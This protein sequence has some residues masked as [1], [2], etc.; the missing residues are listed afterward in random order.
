MSS[1]EG[2][3]ADR[4]KDLTKL[5]NERMASFDTLEKQRQSDFSV[6]CGQLEKG[7]LGEYTTVKEVLKN[8][9]EG[10]T[11][12]WGVI[13][14]VEQKVE[15]I[16]DEIQGTIEKLNTK[17]NEI[18][19]I[20]SSPEQHAKSVTYAEALSYDNKS[21]ITLFVNLPG[22]GNSAADHKE[23][24]DRLESKLLNEK[25]RCN[26][27]YSNKRGLRVVVPTETDATGTKEIV[28]GFSDI[29]EAKVVIYR[30]EHPNIIIRNTPIDD[31]EKLFD[32]LK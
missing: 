7:R 3:Y 22:D 12:Q 8:Y 21:S 30:K 20:Q 11:K 23:L 32:N 13:S 18:V 17:I 2:V 5:Y 29:P 1:L 19:A 9:D 26:G 27:V 16:K 14:K 31:E 6:F 10:L 4:A 25:I 28:S 15:S 24:K